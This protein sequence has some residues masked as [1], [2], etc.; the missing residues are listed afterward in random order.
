MIPVIITPI[1]PT[2]GAPAVSINAAGVSGNAPQVPGAISALPAGS[3]LE[4]F[5]LNRDSAGNPTLRTSL[6]DFLLQS[7]LFLKIGSNVTVRIDASGQN[8]RAHIVEVDGQ[9][10]NP[11]PKTPVPV[12][13]EQPQDDQIIRSSWIPQ[14]G[15]RPDTSAPAELNAILLAPNSEANALQLKQGV[16]LLVRLFNLQLPAPPPSNTIQSPATQTTT[17]TSSYPNV[18]TSSAPITSSNPAVNL[19]P[20][21]PPAAASATAPPVTSATIPLPLPSSS[22]MPAPVIADTQGTIPPAQVIP[23]QAMALNVIG[24]ER[25]GE[26]VL[27]TP[28]GLIKIT[29]GVT[30]ATGTQIQATLALANADAEAVLTTSKESTPLASLAQ[31]W[32]S[33]TQMLN[34]LTEAN[35]GTPPA[36]LTSILPQLQI[37]QSQIQLNAN[38]AGA[39]LFLF[40]AALQG[41]DFRSVIGEKQIKQLEKL[42]HTSL[43]KQAEGEFQMLAKLVTQPPQQGWQSMFMPVLVNGQVEMM[44]WFTK[45]DQEREKD[46]KKRVGAVTRFIVEVSLSQLGDIQLDGLFKQK[47]NGRQFELVVRSH[48]PLDADIQQNIRQIYQ[49]AQATT[50]VTGSVLFLSA[51]Q[52]PP[53]P[54]EGILGSPPDVFA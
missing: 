35:E 8:F 45:R 43:L 9:P 6:G 26:P 34:I 18:Q 31:K 2:T 46:D 4:G 5:V 12:L 38:Q 39:N 27:Q 44:R 29:S 50:G 14:T 48:H 11:E 47:D 17:A 36:T 20:P 28:F 41:Q 40:L 22:S 23:K 33:L 15:G 19:A 3:F 32:T 30:L 51:E 49:E 54:L 7:N 37:G 16:P 1:N 25:D 24:Q 10:V 52:F 53:L 13:P 42:G 21:A